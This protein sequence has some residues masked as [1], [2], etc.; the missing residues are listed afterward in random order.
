MDH[1][2][3]NF[4]D[5]GG[6]PILTSAWAVKKIRR[7]VVLVLLTAAACFLVAVPF[8][9]GALDRS[10]RRVTIRPGSVVSFAGL[11]WSCVYPPV[12]T[13][14]GN[15]YAFFAHQGTGLICN[16][17]S[18]GTGLSDLSG[19]KVLVYQCLPGSKC[20]TL[21]KHARNP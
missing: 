18:P 21:L 2:V 13:R 17:E 19:E 3:A 9:T 6:Q 7:D 10:E 11:D 14:R 12:G 4:E 15:S 8:T 1:R 16:R 5:Q 20:R